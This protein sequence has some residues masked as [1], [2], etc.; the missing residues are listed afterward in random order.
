METCKVEY[1]YLQRTNSVARLFG[2]PNVKPDATYLLDA[3]SNNDATFFI[4]PYQRNYE[5]REGTC[6]I[7][8]DDIKKVAQ[9]NE[10]GE[11]SEHFFG[12][13]VY[14]VEQSGFGVPSRYVLTDG[15]Q[16]ITTTMLFLMALRDSL[17]DSHYQETI[18]NK[19][20]QNSSAAEGSEYKIKLKQVETDW[21]AYKLLALKEDL[22]SK[23]SSSSVLQNY[24]FFLRSLEPL[25]QAE[26]RNLLEIGLSKFQ[27]IT[28]KLEPL[29]NP[30]ENPQEIFE[31]LNSLGQPLSLADLVRNYLLMG[32]SSTDQTMLYNS[33]WLKMERKLPGRL[34]EFIRDW[35]QS[36]QHRFFKVAKE[37][38]FKELYTQFK[39]LVKSRQTSAVF[40]SLL[41]Y[42]GAY[43]EAV[44]LESTGVEKLDTVIADLT[45]IGSTTSYSLIS[46][47]LLRTKN[48]SASSET[49]FQLLKSLRTYLLRRRVIQLSAGENKFFPTIGAHLT[50]IIQATS[51]GDK[52]LEFLSSWEFALRLPNDNELRARLKTMNFYN[53]G[54][55]KNY[56]RLV[57]SMLEEHLTKSRPSLDD[58]KLQLEHIL[59]QT[60]N[61]EWRKDLG[62]RA[63]SIHDEF[64]NNI[65][66]ITLIRHNQELGNKAFELK[67]KVYE[68]HSGLQ[69]SQ[70][71]I[72]K[73]EK[74]DAQAIQSR[75]DYL[76]DLIL[77]SVMEIPLGLR[78]SSNWNQGGSEEPAFDSRRILKQLVG[79][80]LTYIR[81]PRITATV[82][83]GAKVSFEGKAWSLSPL[84]TELRRRNGELKNSGAHQGA[85]YWAWEDTKLVNLD[86]S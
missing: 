29:I 23:L 56:P 45:L 80:T 12:S 55:A 40:E 74:W 51:P 44:C 4:P 59:P 20:I 72:C 71:M 9:A 62:E 52:F 60:L 5:W 54:V 81:D 77:Q 53:F 7:F 69:V 50:T 14:V 58:D 22:P 57:F 67:K 76:I 27:I 17:E 35:M 15:Q 83:E 47:I 34:S 68:S 64:L 19:Y 61:E 18:Q 8:L 3:L 10:R 84:T 24:K 63:E 43:A 65:G 31:S 32:Q 73:L 79:E 6:K 2:E 85:S 26:R 33:Y 75:A 49:A 1:A 25:S 46:E 13:I 37:S 16:R 30:W 70:N 42:S 48:G 36:D 21:E 82:V 38:N 66:N 41:K 39:E 86:F 28:I 11:R 78:D